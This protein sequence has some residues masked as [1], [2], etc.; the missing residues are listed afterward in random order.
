MLASTISFTTTI[1]I[2]DSN[3]YV[4]VTKERNV[5]RALQVISGKA[6]RFTAR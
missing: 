4:L 6:G 3:P 5:P 2:R 1:K